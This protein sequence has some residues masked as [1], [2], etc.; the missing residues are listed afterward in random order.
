MTIDG[1]LQAIRSGGGAGATDE[2]RA[3]LERGAASLSGTGESSARDA[4]SNWRIRQWTT[5]RAG[6]VAVGL[7]EAV[8]ALAAEPEDAQVGL[9]HFEAPGRVFVVFAAD[10]R[11]LGCVGVNERRY[12]YEFRTDDRSR[13]FCDEIVKRMVGLFG[14]CIDEAVGRINRQWSGQDF[15]GDETDLRYHEE[16]EFWANDIVYGAN[17][18]WWKRPPGLRPKRWP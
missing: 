10:E 3:E 7:A 6:I 14:C 16:P 2:L 11:V 5:E 4:A 9:F 13:W 18:R 8:A 15:V 17:S 1:V 12:A